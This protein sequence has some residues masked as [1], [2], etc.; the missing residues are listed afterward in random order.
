M[1]EPEPQGTV[2]TDRAYSFVAL[3]LSSG[4]MWT[5]TGD[6]TIKAT[7]IM[8]DLGWVMRWP[9]PPLETDRANDLLDTLRPHAQALCGRVELLVSDP[10]GI[11]MRAGAGTSIDAIQWAVAAAWRERCTDRPRR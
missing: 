1:P 6:W 7:P 5:H 11:M 9:I 10:A 8:V 3:D 4:Q 2:E